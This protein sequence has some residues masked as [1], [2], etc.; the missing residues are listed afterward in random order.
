MNPELQDVIRAVLVEALELHG[1][2]EAAEF[3]TRARCHFL[4]RWYRFAPFGVTSRKELEPIVIEAS[5]EPY[6]RLDPSWLDPTQ[7]EATD[8]PVPVARTTVRV[9][10]TPLEGK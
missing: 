9:H 7:H 8:A 3:C 5:E 10:G 2:S 1:G 6:P 4:D